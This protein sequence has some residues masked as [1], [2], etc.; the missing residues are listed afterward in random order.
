MEIGQFL[1]SRENSE[2]VYEYLVKYKNRSYL[3]TEWL[4]EQEMESSGKNVKGK[5]NR[6]NKVFA[7]RMA[8]GTYD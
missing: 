3:H 7:Q 1:W 5:L 8:E 4:T 2:G 6:F